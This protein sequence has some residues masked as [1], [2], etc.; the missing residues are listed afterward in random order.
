MRTR[1]AHLHP[2]TRRRVLCLTIVALL[3]PLGIL[4]RFAPLGLRQVIVKYG[5][6]FLWAATIYW[7]IALLLARR[8][9]LSVAI[10]ALVVTTTIEFIKRIQSVQL[11][12]FRDTIAGK[13]LLGRYFS[14]TDIAVYWSAILCAMW[15]DRI[16]G[17]DSCAPRSNIF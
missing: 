11:D 13:L 3:I 7:F 1:L 9:A 8:R 12:I 14:Y 16:A 5:A 10:I 2:L 15:I 4:C 6:S 17:Y